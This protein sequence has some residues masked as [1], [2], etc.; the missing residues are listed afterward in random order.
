MANVFVTGP[1]GLLGSN[2]VRELLARN[3]EVTAMVQEGRDPVTLKGLP[4]TKVYGDVTSVDQLKQLTKGFDYLVHIAAL[5]DMWP[6]RGGKHFLINVEGTK[7]VIDAVLEN[8]IS[9]MIHVGSAGSFGYGTLEK[10]GTEE[11]SYKSAKY[12]IGYTDSKMVGE[13]VVNEAIKK[14]NLPAVIVCPTFMIGP[15]DVKPSSGAIV[16]A[17]AKRKLPALPGGGKNWASVKDVAIGTCNALERGRLGESYILG[18]ENLSFKDAVKKIATAVGQPDYPKFV[19]P[20]F[21]LKTI[22]RFSD[23]YSSV[24]GKPVQLTYPMARVACDDHYFSS[25]KAIRELGLPQTPL[26]EAVK[27]LHRWFKE[28][29]Y[30]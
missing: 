5:T 2:L 22:G 3:Y 25:E 30:L 15:Y 6:T 10:P 27:E 12:G 9:R 4:I 24:S 26:E 18:G 29:N 14:R 23:L 17:V 13:Q 1:D 7:N 16:V 21:V 28:N 11:D 20:D 8:G 19:M